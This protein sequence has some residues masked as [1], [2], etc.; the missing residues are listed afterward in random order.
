MNTY[1]K[2][3]AAEYATMYYLSRHGIGATKVDDGFP[4]VDVIAVNP[5]TARTATIQVKAKKPGQHSIHAS[6]TQ[7]ESADFFVWAVVNDTVGDSGSDR[8]YVIPRAECQEARTKTGFRFGKISNVERYR[9]AWH[10][11]SEAL[12]TG[13]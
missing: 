8:F 6:D 4:H 2:G 11:V 12:Q 1:F 13:G 5:I 7:I 9:D 10:L 3:L